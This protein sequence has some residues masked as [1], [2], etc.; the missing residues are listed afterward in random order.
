MS[1]SVLAGM[2][3]TAA[4]GRGLLVLSQQ[5]PLL[6][7]QRVGLSEEGLEVLRGAVEDHL[8]GSLAV[9]PNARALVPQQQLLWL[10]DTPPG[11]AQLQVSFQLCSHLCKLLHSLWLELCAGRNAC[12]RAEHSV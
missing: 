3:A 4:V 5:A 7:Q 9:G 2:Q 6:A 8:G 1:D 12:E 10:L 11:S